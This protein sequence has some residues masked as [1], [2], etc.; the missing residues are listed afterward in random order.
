MKKRA[1]CSPLFVSPFAI[2]RLEFGQFQIYAY[3]CTV[4]LIIRRRVILSQD[5]KLPPLNILFRQDSIIVCA[6]RRGLWV[7][8]NTLKSVTEDLEVRLCK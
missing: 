6:I 7:L 1:Q 4:L 2:I 5:P 3:I 8:K